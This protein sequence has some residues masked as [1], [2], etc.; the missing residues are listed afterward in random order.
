MLDK[1]KKFKVS[2]LGATGMVGQRFLTL[3]NKHPW[4]EVV[5]IA[6]SKN[7][8]NKSYHDAV[9]NKWVL[10][11]PIPE[12]TKKLIL[13][14]AEDLKKIPEKVKIVF[15]AVDLHQKKDTR[16]FEIQYAKNGYALI[17]T[18]SANR[19]MKKIPMIIPEI[20]HEHLKIIK[21]QQ[22]YY[23]LPKNGFVCV[24]PNCSIQSYIF[25]LD[26]LKKANY[27]IKKIQVTTLQALSG[28]GYK[29]LQNI[30]LRK[31]VIPYIKNEE[32]KTEIEPLKIF[33]SIKKGNIIN[34][35]KIKISA[36][37]T[38]V[39]VIDGHTAIVNVSFKNKI[40]S[41]KK[42]KE[43]LSSYTSLPQIL[44][45]PS[46]PLKPIHLIKDLNRPQPKL[47]INLDK[48]MALS[49]GRIEKDT[50]FDMRFIGLSHNTLR[51]AAGGAILNAE[52]LV[53]ENYI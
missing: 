44:K 13:R 40:P 11:E 48:G 18:S 53:K 25:V 24:K 50:F 45:L 2:V 15:S 6:A 35:T 37:C 14:N 47:D 36:T 7:S 29:A 23:K 39:P 3:L 42:F 46:A 19:K 32:N 17:S 43:I 10:D 27:P 21:E 1:N 12:F 26:A 4:F 5:D 22:K 30:N 16:N 33:G 31:N 41:M 51:G 28:A 20:N 49:I 8:E 38:R 34:S 9:K 52:L